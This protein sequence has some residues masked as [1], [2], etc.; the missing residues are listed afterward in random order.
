MQVST[1][2]QTRHVL[3]LLVSLAVSISFFLPTLYAANIG[4]V[5]PVLGTVA[6][7]IYDSTRNLVYL[8][9]ASRNEVDIYSVGERRLVGSIATGTL[10]SSLA[11]SPDF[12]TLY[13]ASAG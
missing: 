3:L 10:P 12:T 4:T 9:N 13:V 6:D 11:L 8:A 1:I 7:L 2:P 5:V